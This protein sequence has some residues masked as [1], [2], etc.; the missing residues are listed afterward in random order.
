MHSDDS[1][2]VDIC[3]AAYLVSD[4]EVDQIRACELGA[5]PRLEALLKSSIMNTSAHPTAADLETLATLREV[6]PFSGSSSPFYC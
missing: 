3:V 6:S 1:I 2:D 4:D 5:L